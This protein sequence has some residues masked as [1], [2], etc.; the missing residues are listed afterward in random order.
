VD[1]KGAPIAETPAGGDMF[2]DETALPGGLVYRPAFI[3]E[4]EEGALLREIAALP[5]HEAQYKE[6]TARRR[7]V[8]YGSSYDFTDNVLHP[9]E[10]VPGFLLPLRER[11]AA[12][13]DLPATRFGHALV[14][15]YRAGTSLGWHRDVP[16]FGVIVGISLGTACRMRFRP[17]PPRPHR[18]EDVFA[19]E[20]APRSAY[21]LQGDIRWRWQHSIPATP[22]LRHSITFR[23]RVEPWMPHGGA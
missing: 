11:V 15:E 18:R 19:L 22:A 17:Y 3:A 16:Q 12:W 14:T 2:G 9:E 13:V 20:L 8:S 6:Y 23:T 1:E 5:L 7:I 4:D 21:V 10:P